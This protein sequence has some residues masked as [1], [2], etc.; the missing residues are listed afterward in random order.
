LV[1][2]DHI[3]RLA[4]ALTN[5]V[6]FAVA[7]YLQKG[8]LALG[9]SLIVIT[10]AATYYRSRTALADFARH[11]HSVDTLLTAPDGAHAF[12]APFDIRALLT[13][14][15]IEVVAFLAVKTSSRRTIGASLPALA[16]KVALSVE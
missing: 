5:L 8:A 12:L 11:V 4:I 15:L 16:A 10:E 3:W 6:A 2:N 7:Y 13:L 1:V 14:S 9:A